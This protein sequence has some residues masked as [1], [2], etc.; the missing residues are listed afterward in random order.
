M[1]VRAASRRSERLDARDAIAGACSS[2]SAGQA[3]RVAPEP[4]PAPRLR[5]CVGPAN[6]VW[7]AKLASGFSD[8]FSPLSSGFLLAQPANTNGENDAFGYEVASESSIA[9]DYDPSVGRW[10]SKDASRF[11][12]GL[13]L[14]A[15]CD[16]DPINRVDGDGHIWRQVERVLGGGIRILRKIGR[17]EAI[18]LITR[19][20]DVATN[21]AKAGRTLARDVSL[22]SDG[23]GKASDLECHGEEMTSHYHALD[24][25]GRH[26]EGA[27]HVFVDPEL[28]S[29]PWWIPF[30]DSNNNQEF[31][32]EDFIDILSPVPIE[33]SIIDPDPYPA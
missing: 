20:E 12:G 32:P 27:G 15:Y 33:W 5:T 23:T 24:E 29:V 2:R 11:R 21:R 25:R 10:V 8:L 31:D 26:L 28:R 4:T 13:D 14:Y 17:G 3:P 1:N 7:G 16:S 6:D 19:G 18:R 30:L 9:R 22:L